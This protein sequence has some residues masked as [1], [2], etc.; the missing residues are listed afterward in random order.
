M[1]KSTR[2]NLFAFFDQFIYIYIYYI[3]ISIRNG[4]ERA[5]FHNDRFKKHLHWRTLS[6]WNIGPGTKNQND[7][8]SMYNWLWNY[9]PNFLKVKYCKNGFKLSR[10]AILLLK[11]S[12]E[13]EKIIFHEKNLKC[14]KIIHF[15][16]FIFTR[17]FFL[18]LHIKI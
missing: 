2:K 14:R 3:Y 4:G 17:T 6:S 10:I 7:F 8:I 18:L 13:P 1:L 9:V 5:N 16:N 15:T 11:G 12:F